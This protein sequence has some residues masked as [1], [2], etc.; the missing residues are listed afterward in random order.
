MYWWGNKTANSSDIE[1]VLIY[2]VV[3]KM[4]QVSISHIL[5]FMDWENIGSQW[6]VSASEVPA[7]I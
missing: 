3:M 7:I 5:V 4:L 6:E 1:F 2:T